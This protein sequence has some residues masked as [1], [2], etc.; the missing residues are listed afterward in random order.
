MSAPS[1]IARSRV[2]AGFRRLNRARTQLFKGDDHAMQVS[3]L[4][5]RQQFDLNK[6][7]PTWG[8]DYEALV[9]GIDEAA[10]M[11]THEIV[12]GDL[13][14]DTGRYGEC[15]SW[16]CLD[17]RCVGAME[18]IF[19]ARCGWPPPNCVFPSTIDFKF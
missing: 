1:S 14:E 18:R 12:R 19:I 10:D 13:N 16:V 6:D 9:A 8:P 7:V 3:R 2:L 17:A 11:L 5:M 4:Q 15:F